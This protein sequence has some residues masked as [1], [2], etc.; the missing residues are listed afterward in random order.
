MRPGD[1]MFNDSECEEL[2]DHIEEIINQK[3]IERN[4]YFNKED[5]KTTVIFNKFK[6]KFGLRRI[7][8]YCYYVGIS[9]HDITLPDIYNLI[10]HCVENNKINYQLK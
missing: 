1:L 10:I 8:L 5:K 3:I 7:I 2:F 4:I 6:I 9:K